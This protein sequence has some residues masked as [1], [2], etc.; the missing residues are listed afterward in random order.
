M[1]PSTRS[2]PSSSIDDGSFLQVE[3]VNGRGGVGA[4]GE[5][6]LGAAEE[7]SGEDDD[8]G[9][10]SPLARLGG[11]G[12]GVVTARMAP[13]LLLLHRP[14]LLPARGE[15]GVERRPMRSLAVRCCQARPPP[16]HPLPPAASQACFPDGEDDGSSS[17]R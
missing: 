14:G 9:G 13:A 12:R 8:G 4:S 15:V 7:G 3:G 11:E 6:G 1:P 2:S 17:M 5:E 10:A 16:L